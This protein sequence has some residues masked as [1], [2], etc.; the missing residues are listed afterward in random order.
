MHTLLGKT[1]RVI[2]ELCDNRK[3]LIKFHVVS[4][5]EM[6]IIKI[7]ALRKHCDVGEFKR[8]RYST[9]CPHLN[10]GIKFKR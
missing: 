9:E 3:Y 8:N 6:S 5:A 2:C 7:S 1:K 10:F 4:S